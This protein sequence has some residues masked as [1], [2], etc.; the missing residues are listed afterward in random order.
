VQT[1][2]SQ[3]FS[4]ADGRPFEVTWPNTQAAGELWRWNEDHFAG[5]SSPLEEW[6]WLHP[7]GRLRAYEEAGIDAPHMFSGFLI[8]NGFHYVRAS[9]LTGDELERFVR[10]SRAFAARH[11]GACHVWPEYALPRIQ[12]TCDRMKH[13][14][15]DT[16]VGVLAEL[17]NYAFHLTHVAGPAVFG[18][19]IAALGQ[20]L[21]PVVGRAQAELLVEEVGQGADNATVDSDR[22]IARLA[23]L[24]RG[25]PE[26][27]A[28]VRAGRIPSRSELPGSAG[29][30]EQFD[31]FLETYGDRSQTWGIDHPTMREEPDFVWSMVRAAIQA[32]ASPD[33][34]RKAQQ[35]RDE[36]IARI[37]EALAGDRAR[38]EQ[39]MAV[40]E[41]LRGYV[42]VREGRALW[43]LTSGGILRT[44]LLEKGAIL[45]GRGFISCADDIRF[46]LPDE[47][48]PLF[49][50]DAFADLR[51]LVAERQS[52]QEARARIVPPRFISGNPAMLPQASGATSTD[53][54]QGLPGA[55][56]KA[57][58]PARLILGLD[59][60]ETMEPGDV[61]VCAMTSPPWTPLFG[62]ASAIVTD[63]GMALS[64][65]AIAARE[66][67]I[68]AVVGAGDATT[69]I[70]TGDLIEVDGDAGTVTI[71]QR[72]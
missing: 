57:T 51:P 72:A 1:A 36:A 15:P 11:G 27:K 63:S 24:A 23:E 32:Q 22:A 39:A 48:D 7:P 33:D 47:I 14:S 45:A 16:P 25:D 70:R 55:R 28:A 54:I 8:Q 5:P 31:A 61:L 60:A 30:F 18:P 9:R 41:E 46:L 52:E 34:R 44:K 65:P 21:E 13:A 2:T 6:I 17:G 19:L 49:D 56:G 20:M 58:A 3:S 40:A 67:G 42:S 53:K 37:K 62:L 4:A 71:L 10:K 29:F 68:P 43:Q 66:Y 50:N 69:R 64:H 12:R 59:D 35:T 26:L 38:Q